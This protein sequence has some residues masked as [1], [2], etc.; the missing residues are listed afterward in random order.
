M[1]IRTSPNAGGA[2]VVQLVGGGTGGVQT[3]PT[4]YPRG[5]L[6]FEPGSSIQRAF[7]GPSDWSEGER[8]K[9][10]ELHVRPGG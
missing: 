6:V 4:G 8:G 3:L 5:Y 1:C 10:A 2:G 9:T 7:V